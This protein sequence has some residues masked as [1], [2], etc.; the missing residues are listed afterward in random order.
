MKMY[1]HWVTLTCPQEGVLAFP[2]SSALPLTLL[3]RSYP[4]YTTTEEM[5]SRLQGA[6]MEVEKEAIEHMLAGL[7]MHGVLETRRAALGGAKMAD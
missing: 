4:R 6:G 5:M 2:E 1:A 7:W 3:K